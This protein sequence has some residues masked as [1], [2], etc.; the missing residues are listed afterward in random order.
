MGR[1]PSKAS[2]PCK[3]SQVADALIGTWRVRRSLRE[4]QRRITG[5]ANAQPCF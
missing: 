3:V 2:M 1:W 4:V 5:T